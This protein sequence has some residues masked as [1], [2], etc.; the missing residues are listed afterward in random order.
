VSD[1]D[2]LLRGGDFDGARAALS[3]AV[4][5]APGD[6]PARMFLF[7]LLCVMGEWDKAQAALRALASLSP[8]AQML[9]AHYGMAFDAERLRAE[10]F[11]GRAPAPLLVKESAWADGLSE[12]LVAL[13]SGRTEEGL[14]LRDAAFEAASQSAGTLNGQAFDWI[15]D[16][17]SRFGPALEAIVYGKWGL[18]PFDAIATVKSE[19]PRDLRDLVWM[20]AEIF[21]KT[22]QSANAMLPVRY[23]GSEVSA[24]ADIRLS[25]ATAWVDQ[26]WGE[27]GLGQHLLGLSD[28]TDLGVLALRNLTLG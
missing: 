5:K 26:P 11:A 27:A 19:G 21:F 28:G 8:E 15:A 6:Q 16:A 7:Q 9:A 10:V 24:D 23:P 20:P 18:L 13:G 12:A 25:R 17:D 2:E 22:G 14:A 1:A 3:E 4:R